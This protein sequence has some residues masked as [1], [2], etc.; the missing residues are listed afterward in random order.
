[1]VE[2]EAVVEVEA[3]EIEMVE[4]ALTVACMMGV[5]EAVPSLVADVMIQVFSG[6]LVIG[7]GPVSESN[8]V[9]G[10]CWVQVGADKTRA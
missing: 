9:S 7:A 5:D 6:T 1:M 2:A 3:K 10:N 4:L 8:L